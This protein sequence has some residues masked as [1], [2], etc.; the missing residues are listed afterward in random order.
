MKSE[1]C[2]ALLRLARLKHVWF[3]LIG[4]RSS[5]KLPHYPDV[6]PLAQALM[7][8]APDRCVWGTDWPNTNIANM[9]NAGDLADALSEW[10]PD[11][12]VRDRVLVDNPVRLFGFD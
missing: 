1:G 7:A 2:Q 9:P 5:T 11:K 10:L 12:A 4:Y 6:S 8:L 3:K